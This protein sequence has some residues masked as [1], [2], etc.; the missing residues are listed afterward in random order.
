MIKLHE[1]PIYALSKK[2]LSKRYDR[3]KE[4]FRE[5][6]P[7]IDDES[8]RKCVDLETFPQRC[9]NHNHVVGYIDIFVDRQDFIFEIYLPYPETKRY[10]W[11]RSRKIHVRSIIAN[12][13]HFY[14]DLNMSNA[15][16][17]TQIT[18]MLAWVIKDHIPSK[19]YVDRDAFDTVHRH[20]DYKNIF[21]SKRNDG[22]TL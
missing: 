2:A 21:N 9:W 4:R 14:V 6:C 15:D 19:Y 18:E 3:F 5:S 17:Q 22:E 7:T 11:R 16:I 10:D 13:T 1:I 8:F 12:G 20:I